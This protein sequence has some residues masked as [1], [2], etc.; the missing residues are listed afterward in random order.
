M[1]ALCYFN[2]LRNI[3]LRLLQV[4]L[5]GSPWGGE[6]NTK[7]LNN[8]LRL[9]ADMC[10][11]NHLIGSQRGCSFTAIC[12]LQQF[13]APLCK[14]YESLQSKCSVWFQRLQQLCNQPLICM[15]L[16]LL[17]FFNYSLIWSLFPSSVSKG[18]KRHFPQWERT[19]AASSS[20][21]FCYIFYYFSF[22]IVFLM[23]NNVSVSPEGAERWSGSCDVVNSKTRAN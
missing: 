11:G 5:C 16:F 10:V 3:T 22:E 18:F 14:V 8:Q 12:R 13:V 6:H 21:K 2:T 1:Q 7:L 17:L 20:M 15:L 23:W 4:F 19:E 9:L